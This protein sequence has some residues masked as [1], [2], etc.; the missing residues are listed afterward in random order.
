MAACWNK[1]KIP[2][3]NSPMSLAR[4]S[5]Y[6]LWVTYKQVAHSFTHANSVKDLCKSLQSLHVQCHHCFMCLLLSTMSLLGTMLLPTFC[7][8]YCTVGRCNAYTSSWSLCRGR[9]CLHKFMTLLSWLNRLITMSLRCIWVRTASEG[10][11]PGGENWHL[12]H[13]CE[14]YY[15]LN[16]PFYRMLSCNRAI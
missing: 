7:G 5:G 2:M 12:D 11:Q 13:L 3:Q 9:W 1:G 4:R 8:R 14:K 6:S 16:P 15:M 10:E